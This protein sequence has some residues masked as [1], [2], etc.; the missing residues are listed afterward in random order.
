[1]VTVTTET[2]H[3]DI[4]VLTHEPLDP[5]KIEA[6]VR[7][8]KAGAVVSFVGYTRDEFQ[9]KTVTHLE[10]ES[11]TSLAIKTL[12]SIL[13][14]ARNLPAPAATTHH[15]FDHSHHVE[16]RP[17]NEAP[18]PI[19][20]TSMTVH[21]LL[22]SSPPL[23]PSLVICVATPHRKEAFVVCEW[24]LERVKERLQVWKREW[25]ADGT[26]FRGK[27]GEG[28]NGMGGRA[29]PPNAVWKENIPTPLRD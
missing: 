15:C 17:I 22:G 4:G 23:T 24:L 26:E 11:Y 9:G 12:R 14:E 1:M 21:H 6:T 7:S 25:Y 3:G 5:A 13:I 19:E 10:Y 28:P 8:T 20:I 29:V 27:D 18:P 2:E 16:E